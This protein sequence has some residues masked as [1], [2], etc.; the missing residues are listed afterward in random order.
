MAIGAVGD[1]DPEV[2]RRSI[3][4]HRTAFAEAFGNAFQLDKAEVVVELM[5]DRYS[6][7]LR[8]VVGE[9]DA[10]KAR[11]SWPRVLR[12]RQ[13]GSRRTISRLVA[14]AVE[15]VG[16]MNDLALELRERFPS[17]VGDIPSN[18]KQP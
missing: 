11:E 14:C 17:T 12:S 13:A 7:E 5:E 18:L 16:P 3:A 8:A 4:A 15:S 1:E 10:S 6:V 9:I 2:V